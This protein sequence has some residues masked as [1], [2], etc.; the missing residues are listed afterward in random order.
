MDKY[1][2]GKYVPYNTPIHKLDPRLKIVAMI[3]MMVCVF[4]SFSSWTLTFVMSGINA[5]V[6][7]ALMLISKVR[8]RDLLI[9]LRSIWFLII[10]LT[11]IN[12]FIPPNGSKHL[13][14]VNG[15]FKLYAE[16]FLQSG[17]II[18]RL[19][20][21]FSIAM[22]LTATTSP[23]ELTF[24]FSWFMKPLKKV[25]FPVEEIAMTMSIALRFIPTL[26]EETNR[27]YKAQAAR[28]CDFKHG[29]LKTK[30]K[31]IIAL[32]IPLF[33]TSFAMS[34]DLALA[35]EARGYNPKKER[36]RY[37]E[38][39]WKIKDSVSLFVVSLYLAGFITLI[40][41]RFDFIKL[42]FPLVW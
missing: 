26:I 25:K 30:F 11:L 15:G 22:I 38:L 35:L 13:I 40:A 17:K 33:V 27:I 34:D 10:L 1:I 32:I 37:R 6:I 42:L 24:G 12:I 28:G 2:L 36:T 19:M 9:Q 41:T 21:M 31:G 5:V 16:S 23:Q 20:E 4:F 3:M 39:N 7:F 14:A 18:L 29:N 8:L